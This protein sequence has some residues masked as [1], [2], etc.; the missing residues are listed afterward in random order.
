MPFSVGAASCDPNRHESLD[1][2]VEE[3]DR[4]MYRAQASCRMTGTDPKA[5]PQV[6]RS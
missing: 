1:D 4:R 5:R 3:A 6:A 2:L